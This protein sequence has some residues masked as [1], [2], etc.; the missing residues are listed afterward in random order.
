[1]PTLRTVK[2]WLIRDGLFYSCIGIHALHL[3]EMEWGI[4]AIKV[5]FILL[6]VQVHNNADEMLCCH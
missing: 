3:W 2:Q 5:H 6:C 4:S 1:M